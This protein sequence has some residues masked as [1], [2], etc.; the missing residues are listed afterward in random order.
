MLFHAISGY[1]LGGSVV[2]LFAKIGA[3]IYTKATDIGAD[4]IGKSENNNTRESHR[5]PATIA[6]NVVDVTSLG[7]D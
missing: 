2:T 5:N 7:V 6:R 4:L 3:G 1:G